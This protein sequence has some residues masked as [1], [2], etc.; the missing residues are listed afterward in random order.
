M[1]KKSA[2][3]LM[4]R[5]T[6]DDLQVL[7]VHPGG[8]F[9]RNKDLSAWSIPKGEYSEDE[10]PEAT[11]RREFTEETGLVPDGKLRSLGTIRQAGGK[12]VTGFAIEGNFDVA[13]LVS[14]VFEIEWPPRSGHLQSFPEVDRAEWFSLA[15]A[16]RKIIA[17]QRPLLD[18]L[19]QLL[20]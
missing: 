18:R 6:G 12:L 1:A 17:G 8:P 5:K 4:Y 11:A 3:I 14:N 19:E 16:H 15:D 10:D 13:T 7:L 20:A 9:W 2:G